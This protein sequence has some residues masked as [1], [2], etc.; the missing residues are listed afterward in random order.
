MAAV[1]NL[2]GGSVSIGRILSRTLGAITGNPGVMLGIAFLFGALPQ[3]ALG[4]LQTLASTGQLAPIDTGATVVIAIL[5]ALI[6]IVL[7]MIVQG[8][9]VRATMTEI[10]GERATFSQCV[11]SGFS[12]AL[13]MLGIGILV[14]L[15]VGVGFLLLI[16]PGVIF[17][18]MWSVSIPVTVV[19]RRSVIDS[20]SRSS[21]LT[22]GARGII[23]ALMLIIWV[24]TIGAGLISGMVGTAITG[25]EVATPAMRDWLQFAALAADAVVTTLVTV[26]ASAIPTA[27]YVELR[28]WKEGPIADTLSDIFA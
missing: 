16:V 18:L 21:D 11:V 1:Y 17:Y 7:A 2:S 27:L 15:G 6:G 25:L 23:F 4:Y 13:P 12:R 26:F 9:L 19:E 10:E 24:L 22:S 20:M 28:E 14:A 5:A 3:T 8:G